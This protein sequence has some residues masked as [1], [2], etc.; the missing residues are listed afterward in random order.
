MALNSF[1]CVDM[2][3]KNYLLAHCTNKCSCYSIFFGDRRFI[4]FVLPS[5][6]H[7]GSYCFFSTVSHC[8]DVPC[9]HG[10]ICRVGGLGKFITHMRWR[11]YM[12]TRGIMLFSSHMYVLET[13]ST[14]YLFVLCLI[15]YFHLS[16][17]L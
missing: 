9:Q 14:V 7:S 1:N 2:L 6:M 5:A 16:L 4:V 13:R 15:S 11:H 3:L 10:L 8:L 17:L 12:T